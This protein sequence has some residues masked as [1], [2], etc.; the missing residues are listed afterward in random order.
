MG[1]VRTVLNK[2]LV[3]LRGP[4][5]CPSSMPREM[6]RARESYE[7]FLMGEPPHTFFGVYP[8]LRCGGNT[9][10]EEGEVRLG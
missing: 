6:T 8:L 2:I 7:S 4:S 9:A 3:N 5:P 10:V 1:S